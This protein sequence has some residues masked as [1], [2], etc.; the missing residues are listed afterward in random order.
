MLGLDPGVALALVLSVASA[1]LCVGYGV[2]RWNAD[3]DQDEVPPDGLPTPSVAGRA[4]EK[5]LSAE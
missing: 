4:K 1:G 3:D 2:M 5:E